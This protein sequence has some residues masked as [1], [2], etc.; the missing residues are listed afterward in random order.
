MISILE[1]K[2]GPHGYEIAFL[3]QGDILN[4]YVG[5]LAY[6]VT[7]EVLSNVFGEHGE[8][9]SVKIIMDTY[10]GRSKG[11]GFIEMA[12]QAEAEAAIQE[13]N[14]ISLNGR[15]LIVNEA[16]PRKE[17]APRFSRY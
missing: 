10:S 16:R 15:N 11:F 5:N 13:L 12:H 1:E 4:I 3:L 9:T 2:D 17:R 7:E 8:V 6:E 14:S